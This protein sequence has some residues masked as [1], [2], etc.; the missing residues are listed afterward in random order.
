MVTPADNAQEE[1]KNL[2]AGS[3]VSYLAGDPRVCECGALFDATPPYSRCGQS[4]GALSQED[5]VVPGAA[6]RF[7]AGQTVRDRGLLGERYP[8]TAILIRYQRGASD[9]RMGGATL[10]AMS[11]SGSGNRD[12]PPRCQS[13]L[14]VAEHVGRR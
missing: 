13:L 5:C 10:P 2:A 9:A 4:N 14:V 1:E 8:S 7:D 11:N 3:A 6:Y 12:L